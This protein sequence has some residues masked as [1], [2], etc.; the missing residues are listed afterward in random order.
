MM[1]HYVLD[2]YNPEPTER[3][4]YVAG[5]ILNDILGI[6]YR[7]VSDK[8]LSGGKVDIDYSHEDGGDGLKIIPSGLLNKRGVEQVIPDVSWAGKLPL[9]FPSNQNGEFPFDIFSASFYMLSRYEEYQDFHPDVHGRFSGS[10]SFACTNGFLKIPVV[11]MWARM[12][13]RELSARNPQIIV[14][15]NSFN[16]LMTFDIDQ[17]YA[18]I[19]HGFLRNTAG[20]FK[21]F[22][23]KCS[24]PLFRLK[25]LLGRGE[26]PYNLFGY[27]TSQVKKHDAKAMFF[28]PVGQRNDHD[29]NPSWLDR[30]YQTLIKRISS[31]YETGIHSSYFSSGR[32]EVLSEEI[33]HFNEIAGFNVSKCRQHWLLLRVPSTYRSFIGAGI[34]VDYTMGFADETGFRAGIARPFPFYD[35]LKEEITDLTIVPFQVMDGTLMQY[36]SLRPDEAIADIRSLIEVT[37]EAGGLFVSLWHNTSLTESCG[38]EGWR[39]VFEETLRIQ[40]L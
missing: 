16:A 6:S 1:S 14:K 9:L 25:T 40:K 19:G 38:W 22:F 29:K 20:F 8:H 17:A 2:I 37:R 27:M 10:S 13:G 33:E 39:R 5:V 18:F 23:S 32:P 31:E 36:K 28:F 26:D 7:V 24:N 35:L 21:D 3:F 30:N 11:D 4:K 15:E 34:K 12:L